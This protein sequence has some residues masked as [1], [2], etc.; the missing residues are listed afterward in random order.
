MD[1]LLSTEVAAALVIK[2]NSWKSTQSRA[3]VWSYSMQIACQRVCV[4]NGTGGDLEANKEGGRL[5]QKEQST[6]ESVQHEWTF[7][8][9]SAYLRRNILQYTTTNPEIYNYC[10]FSSKSNT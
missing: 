2:V 9:F 5:S 7:Q 6:M 10:H 8:L 1:N 4:R 3:W